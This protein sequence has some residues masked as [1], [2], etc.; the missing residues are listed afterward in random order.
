MGRHDR[1]RL[2]FAI[3]TGGYVWEFDLDWANPTQLFRVNSLGAITYDPEN[4]SL[5]ISQFSSATI[6]EYSRTGTLLRSW[7]APHDQC[8]ALALDHADGTLWIHNR[9]AQG[10]IEQ[11]DKDGSLLNTIVVPGL[12]T[13]NALGGEF[14]FGGSTP[15]NL[16]ASGDC[17]GQMTFTAGGMTAGGNVAFA[18]AFGEGNFVIPGGTCAGTTLGLNATVQLGAIERA[19]RSG[20]AV[21]TTNVPRA[22][23]GRVFVQAI[24]INTCATTNVVGI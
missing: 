18:Y 12:N 15:P 3:D 9:R 20:F 22:A 14:A 5:W 16:T 6:A 4:D 7:A 13:Q 23:C 2:N 11:Y 10:T 8:M 24:D 19:D 1:R 21:L 17:P